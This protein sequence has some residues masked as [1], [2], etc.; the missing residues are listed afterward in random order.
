MA[1]RCGPCKLLLAA[2]LA[3]YC[4][5]LT[6]SVYSVPLALRRRLFTCGGGAVARSD[7]PTADAAPPH[8]LILQAADEQYA[9]LLA[10]SRAAHVRYAARHNYTFETKL[11]PVSG[12]VPYANL[13]RVWRLFDESEASPLRFDW[14]VYLDADALISGRD[15]FEALARANAAHALALCPGHKVP[16][17]AWDVNDGVFLANLRHPQTRQLACSW[18]R[19]AQWEAWRA[20]SWLTGWYRTYVMR[21]RRLPWISSQRL[22]HQV[23]ADLA[24]SPD[25]PAQQQAW[26]VYPHGPS[27]VFNYDGALVRHAVYAKSWA[28]KAGGVPS[29]GLKLAW[30]KQYV[31]AMERGEANATRRR[32]HAHARAPRRQAGPR[33]G[34][35]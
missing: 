7:A 34:L 16:R 31:A 35:V 33:R 20:T 28:H 2:L 5:C 8:V 32:R 17:G 18:R 25:A 3:A 29:A 19:R 11:G 15:S 24:A 10:T 22:L 26:R 9:E 14:L 6:V 23:L 4:V 13:H 21:V 30:M 12:G 1:R 27:C